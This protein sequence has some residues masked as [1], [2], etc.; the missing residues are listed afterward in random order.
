MQ[1][2]I[3]SEFYGLARPGKTFRRVRAHVGPCRVG[4]TAGG[5]K[6]SGIAS[7][8]TYKLKR[9]RTEPWIGPFTLSIAPS[10]APIS[11]PLVQRGGPAT[12]ALGRSQGGFSTKLNVRAEGHGKPMAFVLQPGHRHESQAF[13]RL[14][15]CGAV[16]RRGVGRPRL[17]P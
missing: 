13:E 3:S 5:S 6:G 9:T 4:I 15:D 10:C 12:E 16:K 7:L 8:L 2:I 14:M 1:Y 11:T 17:R